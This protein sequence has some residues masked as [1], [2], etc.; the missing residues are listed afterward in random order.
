[1]ESGEREREMESG[2]LSSIGGNVGMPGC[3]QGASQ[4]A[5][6]LACGRP[7]EPL[8]ISGL[9]CGEEAFLEASFIRTQRCS[10]DP[11]RIP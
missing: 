2:M 3:C 9:P 5:D 10:K 4:G 8:C 6:P 1:M 7:N 11:H